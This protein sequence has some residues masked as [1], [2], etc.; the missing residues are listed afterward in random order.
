MTAVDDAP[1]GRPDPAVTPVLE[2]EHLNVTFKIRRGVFGTVPLRAVDD[3]S[4]TLGER[5]TLGLVGESGSGKSTTGRALLRLI[6]PDSGT[7]RL[8]GTDV[9]AADRGQLRGLR[10]NMQM[11]FQD[12]YSS[13]DPSM[14]V[15]ESVAEPLDTHDRLKG[16]ER[17]DRVR[18]LLEHVGLGEHHMQR[19]PYE[20][21]GGQRQRVA[22]ARAIAVNP[23]LLV[24]DEA[25]S[26]LDVSTQNQIINLLEDLQD[27]F[28]IS[29]LFIAHDL[30]VVRHLAQEVA[31]M[32]LGA[33][34]EVGPTERLFSHPAHPYTEALLSAVPVPIPWLQRTRERI[35]L[36][37]DLPDPTN[38][39]PGCRFHTRCPYVMDVCRE[40]V[41]E[42][43]PVDG[44]GTV[45]CHLQT[46]GPTL[47][48]GS[49]TEISVTKRSKVWSP[50]L[51]DGGAGGD[52]APAPTLD[53]A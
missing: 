28:G 29:Y 21:S 7:V 1:T 2:V 43:T 27:E 34:V 22:I 16:R 39:P 20:F 18:Y 13:L 11:V 53:E 19:Y 15:A 33:I 8:D 31:V 9:T 41:P 51:D 42:H 44:G 24:C 49:V 52:P 46:T 10:R 4:F 38:P 50:G 40:I 5:A 36:P 30:A 14:V 32:Y 45:A 17:D 12:P 35:I 23:R 47:A 26:A 3:V 37:G 48:G 25:V 6:E